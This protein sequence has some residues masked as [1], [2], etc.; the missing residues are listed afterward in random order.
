MGLAVVFAGSLDASSASASHVPTISPSLGHPDLAGG[1][2][3]DSQ[4]PLRVHVPSGRSGVAKVS[5]KAPAVSLS[6]KLLTAGVAPLVTDPQGDQLSLALEIGPPS[7]DNEVLCG[8]Y[9]DW[10]PISDGSVTDVCITTDL[11]DSISGNSAPANN[12]ESDNWYDACGDLVR[13][14]LWSPVYT[15]SDPG[16]LDSGSVGADALLTVPTSGVCYG[17]WTVTVSLSQ[18]FTDGQTLTD[19]ESHQ[20]YVSGAGPLPSVDGSGLGSGNAMVHDPSPCAGDPV[21]CTSGDFSE[22]FTDVSVPGRGPGLDLTRTYNSLSASTE[23]LFGYGWRS[24]YE[25]NLVVNG[26]GSVTVT[27]ADGSQVTAT[28][29]GFGGYVPPTWADARLT[30]NSDGSWTFVSQQTTTYTFNS[31]GRLTAISD[32]NGFSTELA[33]NGSGQLSRVTDSENRT[34]TFS[35]GTNGFVSQI[36][37]PAGQLTQYG[38]DTAGN[39]TSVIDPA[40]REYQFGYDAN[41]LLQTVTDP[42]QGVTT[43]VYDGPGRVT[44][45]TDPAGLITRFAYNGDNYSAAGGTTTITDPHGNITVENYTNGLMMSK[46]VGSGTSSAATWN[47]QYD[48]NTFAVTSVTDP[49]NHTTTSSYDSAGNLLTATDALNHTTT[50]TYNYLNQ[51]LTVADPAGIET[52]SSYDLS[53]NLLRKT[54]VGVGGSPAE[55]TNYSYTDGIPGDLSEVSDPAGHLTDYTYDNQGDIA[56]VTTHPSSGV[57]DTTAFAYDQLGRKICEASPDATALGVQCAGAG[58]PRVA[59]T[60]TWTYNADGNITSLTDPRGKETDYSYDGDGNQTMVTDPIGNVTK[61]NYDADSRKSTVIAGYGT[62]AAATT[63]HRYDIQPATGACSSAVTG[64]TYCTTS[65]DPGGQTTVDYFNSRNEQIE[66]TQPSSGTSTSTYDPAGNLSTVTTNGGKATYAYNAANELTSITYSNPSTGYA[67]AANVSYAYDPDGNRTSM[68]DGSGTTTYGYDSLERLS[69]TKNGAGAII[70]YGYDLDNEITSITYPGRNQMVS[71]TWDG[72]G[73][74]SNVT[75]WLGKSTNFNYD[76]DGNLTSQTNPNSTSISST[77]DAND[78]P[79]TTQDAPTSSPASPLASLTYTYNPDS[80]VQTETDTGT[81][82]PTSQTYGYDPLDRLNTA[83]T[84]SYTYDASGDPTQLAQAAQTFNAAHQLTSQAPTISRVGTSSAGDNGTGSALTVTLPSGVQPNDQIL[85]AVTLPGN[86]TIKSTPSG[87]TQIGSYNSGTGASNTELV[88][89]RRTAQTGDT[90]VTVTFSKTFAKAATLI[91]YRGVNPVTPID[92]NPIGNSAS[93][94]SVAAPSVTT[95]K[96]ADE[97]VVALGANSSATGTWTAPSQMTTQRSQAGGPTIANAIADQALTSSGPTGT[98][99]AT[100]STTGSL[101]AATL[102]LQPAQTSYAYDSLGDRTSITTPGG[103][104]SLGYNQL[105]RLTSYGSTTYTYNGDGLRV[106]KTTGHTSEAFT[107]S[108]SGQNGTP[109]LL[110]DGSTDY[111][112]GPDGHPLEQIN[113]STAIYYFHD[114]LGSTRALTN[115]SGTLANTY[116]YTPYGTLAASTGPA[117]NPIGFAGSYTDPESGLLYLQHRY[118]DP[119]TAQFTSV[120]SAVDQTGTPYAYVDGDPVDAIDPL[121]MWGWNPISDITQAAGDAG[122]AVQH[123]WRGITQ[124]AIAA[125]AVGVAVASGGSLSGVSAVL[126]S[127]AIGAISSGASYDVGCVDTKAGCTATGVL[128]AII[129]GGVSGG[130]A[131]GLGESVCGDNSRCL[132]AL[133]VAIGAGTATAGYYV[134]SELEGK[135]PSGNGAVGAAESGGLGGLSLSQSDWNS[136]WSTLKKAFASGAGGDG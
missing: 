2:N 48:P 33:Y 101:V 132:S 19:T 123:H 5:G 51:P 88:L 1:E 136:L 3:S 66:E 121:G 32:L 44:K 133:G 94:T 60:T 26:D 102:A 97:L 25:A 99:T 42:N 12:T 80:Q 84:G 77:Y 79:L 36:Q 54:V 91:V 45:Q 112:N 7:G 72:A 120:D 21:N 100:F 125:T 76:A 62:S 46:T 110:V 24:A 59:D 58:Q 10:A 109:Q 126:A 127:A 78:N 6:G 134:S 93:G 96:A 56:T 31:A 9:Y 87:Y 50:Y 11:T 61:T 89:Y 53:G 69:S 108:P 70:G 23:G 39:L 81:P 30:Q 117:T 15:T 107:W 41:H 85:L 82:G 18:T 64:A 57:N 105:G 43:N 95:T 17:P 83:S 16:R 40:N 27:E 130:V 128:T 104:T 86:Q 90:S 92:A 114:K 118:Y 8:L 113:G 20:F 35:Y 106:S 74:E 63:T 119:T 22:T 38:Y 135:C 71:Q 103:T 98:R 131:G 67:A 47:Y 65:I 49:N 14:S 28:P 55:T 115:T 34:I 37:D 73:R 129:V 75:D 111:I 29:D 68:T 52:L 124:V 122:G 116:T 13:H 4:K